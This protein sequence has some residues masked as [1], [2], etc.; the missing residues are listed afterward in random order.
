MIFLVSIHCNNGSYD[1][2]HCCFPNCN[3][4]W[5]ICSRNLRIEGIATFSLDTIMYEGMGLEFNKE[6]Q[7]LHVPQCQWRWLFIEL[8]FIEH[9]SR[10]PS[11]TKSS[12]CKMTRMNNQVKTLVLGPQ[13]S[14]GQWC[15]S[16]QQASQWILGIHI[17]NI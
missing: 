6:H 9:T 8:I 16:T 1:T 3:Q 7:A 14:S 5:K 12:D 4:I 17:N 10:N 15:M 11:W 2:L 13:I